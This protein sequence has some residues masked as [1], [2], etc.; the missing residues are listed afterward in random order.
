MNT[1]V[2]VGI[3]VIL[4]LIGIVLSFSG[5]PK[6]FY[7]S[8]TA[9]EII[10]NNQI[11]ITIGKISKDTTKHLLKSSTTYNLK[12]E[13]LLTALQDI[14]LENTNFYINC[15]N[16]SGR[17]INCTNGNTLSEQKQNWDFDRDK[18]RL[19]KTPL[20]TTLVPLSNSLSYSPEF[21]GI[22]LSIKKI[23]FYFASIPYSRTNLTS[24]TTPD[25]LAAIQT[26]FEVLESK[27]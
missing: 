8:T 23:V 5:Y 11:S 24:T 19:T 2:L 10:K 9:N 26:D 22:D 1:K 14:R 27:R 15:L 13:I 17:I 4:S 18:S 25:L 6:L 12:I 21:F 20:D 7:G 3:V 16:D